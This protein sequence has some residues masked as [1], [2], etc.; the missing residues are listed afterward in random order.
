[1]GVCERDILQNAGLVNKPGPCDP[2]RIKGNKTGN[3]L[4]TKKFLKSLLC[5]ALFH[6]Y[7]CIF[8]LFITQL[9]IFGIRF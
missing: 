2:Y 7:V 9:M 3:S 1:M 8:S 4:W 5:I 6:F